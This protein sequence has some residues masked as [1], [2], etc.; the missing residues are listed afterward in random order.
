MRQVCRE[1]AA[2]RQ[3]MP[4]GTGHA[5]MEVG[6]ALDPRQVSPRAGPSPRSDAGPAARS[7][8]VVQCLARA[9]RRAW[10]SWRTHGVGDVGAGL[11]NVRSPVGDVVSQ[12]ATRSRAERASH[13]DRGEPA[14]R[15]GVEARG[16]QTRATAGRRSADRTSRGRTW[17]DRRR[18][19]SSA[20][21]ARAVASAQRSMVGIGGGRT[22]CRLRRGRGGTSAARPTSAALQLEP[23]SAFRR[24]YAR[25]AGTRGR[26]VPAGVAVY[27]LLLR[28]PASRPERHSS[29]TRPSPRPATRG[30]RLRPRPWRIMT[31]CRR[32]S[33][34]PT[35]GA[36]SSP[37]STA[38]SFGGSGGWS[39]RATP[40]GTA[41]GRRPSAPA[42]GASA[43]TGTTATPSTIRTVAAVVVAVP[44]PVPPRSDPCGRW[45][46]ASTCWWRSRRFPAAGRLRAGP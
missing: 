21:R 11:G 3:A 29:W 14:A 39:P 32:P 2:A 35:S 42:T 5:D 26:P 16:R 44:P 8:W 43:A 38:G 9:V 36:A 1:V 18:T 22:D 37:G 15:P 10:S 20:T 45:P 23:R 46:P 27:G 7:A 24:F 25:R 33:M 28:R 19:C 30:L 40:A 31:P 4:T 6:A 17:R 13:V 41:A 34:S 12:P